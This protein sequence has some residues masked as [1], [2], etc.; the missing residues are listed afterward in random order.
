MLLSFK[1]RFVKLIADK[2]KTQS[3]RNIAV[4]GQERKKTRFKKNLKIDFVI[5]NQTAKQYIF[6]FAVCSNVDIIYMDLATDRIWREDEHILF[7]VESFAKSDGFECYEDLKQFIVEL[8]KLNGSETIVMDR[9]QWGEDYCEYRYKYNKSAID[10]MEANPKIQTYEIV[11][12]LGDV[13][14]IN[15]DETVKTSIV[16]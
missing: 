7:D 5:N 10:R 4:V 1:H 3:L 6:G 15:K 13:V 11:N 8:Y 16:I 9:I 14:T 2:T 12:R